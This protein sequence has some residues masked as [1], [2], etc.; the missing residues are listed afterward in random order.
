MPLTK[1]QF[2]LGID[3]D[4]QCRMGQIYHLLCGSRELAYSSDELHQ[5]ILGAGP[6]ETG[7]EQFDLA[8][9]V[10]VRISAVEKR[11]VGEVDYYALLQEFDTTTWERDYRTV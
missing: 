4:I 1:R 8:L 10:L 7:R 11:W 2:E 6:E 9:D 3:D 5:I